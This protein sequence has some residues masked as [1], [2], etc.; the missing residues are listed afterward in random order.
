MFG[1]PLTGVVVVQF[2]ADARGRVVCTDAPPG[3]DVRLA[4]AAR[5][6]VVRSVF[7]PARADG[8]AVPA[9]GKMTINFGEG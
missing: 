5:E 9:H 7:Q 1:R 6:A 8:V 3:T 4:T 2:I